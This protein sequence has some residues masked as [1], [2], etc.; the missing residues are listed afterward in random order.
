MKRYFIVG[1]D[2]DC[3]KTY[4]TSR[5][6]NHLRQK[7]Y[8]A[9]AIKPVASGCFERDGTLISEDAEQLARA[10]GSPGIDISPWRFKPPVSPHIAAAEVGVRLSAKGIMDFCDA[11]VFANFD[12]LLIEGAGG[13]MVPLNEH[14]TWLDFLKISEFPVILVVGMQLGC[15][16][17]ALLTAYALNAHNIPCVGWI[18]NCL[19]NN[20][21]ALSEN[22][23]TLSEKIAFPLLETI[24]YQGDIG[25]NRIVF[26]I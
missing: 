10:N 25:A 1:T 15:I 21:L 7:G 11:H 19:D 18:A 24:G 2:T 17:H 13:L 12:V 26:D 3:G 14:E 9:L 5:L 6:V 20:M 8:C 23:Q 16:N 22:I 4:V